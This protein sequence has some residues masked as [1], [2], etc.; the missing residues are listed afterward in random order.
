VLESLGVPLAGGPPLANGGGVLRGRV[1]LL[2]GGVASLAR[3]TLLGARGKVAVARLMA[4]LPN[5]HVTKLGGVT[6]AEWVADQSLPG[7]AELLVGMLARVATYC[8]APDEAS[9]DMVVGQIQMAMRHG[10]RYVDGGWQTLVDSLASD[11]CIERGTVL[12]LLRDGADIV[13]ARAGATP[14]VAAAAVVA[15]GTPEVAA[16]LLDRPTFDTGPA[17]EA[18]CLDLATSAPAEPGLL[19]GVDSPQYL[20]NHCPPARL[21]PAGT[22]VVHVARYLTTGEQHDPHETRAELMAHAALAGLTPEVITDS[23]Y[24]HRMTVVGGMAVAR[25]G[26]LTGRPSVN[27]SRIAGVFLAGDWVGPR[28]HLLDAAL[29]SAEDAAARAD[30]AVRTATLVA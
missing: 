30:R 1:G 17:V 6:F 13:V 21:A 3:T 19:L 18:A 23:R 15:V 12:S 10:V 29:A 24:L 5:L 8:N 9:A 14:V 7:E 27:D 16:R 26:G 2:P 22:S 4:R 28:G 20:S 25:L 11:L